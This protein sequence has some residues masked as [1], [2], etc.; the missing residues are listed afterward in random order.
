MCEY[1]A[2]RMV[3]EQL[4]LIEHGQDS[5]N[6]GIHVCRRRLGHGEVAM[7]YV[8]GTCF[9]NQ[10]LGQILFAHKLVVAP[11][12]DVDDIARTMFH[13]LRLS[14]GD[15]T[16]PVTSAEGRWLRMG[17]KMDGGWYGDEAMERR[18]GRQDQD[19]AMVC[20]AGDGQRWEG[21]SSD[22]MEASA[23]EAGGQS[24]GGK[25]G[26]GLGNDDVSRDGLDDGRSCSG[27]WRVERM[28]MGRWADG[29]TGKRFAA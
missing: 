28:P 27:Q 25:G 11:P 13:C 26:Q 16:E 18:A 3:R 21:A 6:I 22:A 12:V 15:R 14:R 7:A 17:C 19:E 5:I 10:G 1:L 4:T 8:S 29:H 24:D 2:S 23:G 9:G 20:R